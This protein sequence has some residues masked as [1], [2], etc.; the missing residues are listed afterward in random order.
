VILLL[1]DLVKRG[2]RD[3]SGRRDG[4]G[5]PCLPDQDQQPRASDLSRE[6]ADQTAAC[7]LL[8]RGRP[9]DAALDLIASDQ[10]RPVPAR[11]AKKCFF[12]KLDAG[13][14]GDTVRYVGITGRT[15]SAALLNAIIIAYTA[16]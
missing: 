3:R 5:D 10:P 6:Q 16:V 4:W 8:R 2:A 1:D 15:A 13:S 11:R 12:R 14:F 9:D 7:R